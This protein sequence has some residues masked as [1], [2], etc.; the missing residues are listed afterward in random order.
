MR[1]EEDDIMKVIM[2]NIIEEIKRKLCRPKK[3]WM[4]CMKGNLKKVGIVH[5]RRMT[6]KGINTFKY[7]VSLSWHLQQTQQDLF[8]ML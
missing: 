3:M 4:D 6:W 8:K 5:W 2:L 7:H 1:R